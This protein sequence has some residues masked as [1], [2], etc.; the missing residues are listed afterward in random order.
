MILFGALYS[1]TTTYLSCMM[2][3]ISATNG[4]LKIDVAFELTFNRKNMEYIPEKNN[5]H[6]FWIVHCILSLSELRA[7]A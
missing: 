6:L 5:P 2:D 7:G 3:R 1:G 4:F